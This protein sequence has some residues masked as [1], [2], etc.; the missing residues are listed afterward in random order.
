MNLFRNAFR[1]GRSG[2][3][4]GLLLAWG[5]GAP[6]E[7]DP[8]IAP[9]KAQIELGFVTDGAYVPCENGSEAPVIWGLQGGTW[10]M[11]VLRTRGIA[12]PSHIEATLTLLD[13]ERLGEAN[14]V[15]ELGMSKSGWLE[16]DRFS[17]PV[18]HAPPDQYESISDLYGKPAVIEVR[19][20]D[21]EERAA[22]FSVEV[23]LVEA[24]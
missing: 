14:L 6:P 22:D 16:T 10:T 20:A 19:V 9:G 24:D 5:C 3:A 12:T 7:D 2:T 15:D 1:R 11:P 18:Q 23:T 17:I 13:G 21:D 8:N 4:L